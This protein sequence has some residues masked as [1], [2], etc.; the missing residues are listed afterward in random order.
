MGSEYEYFAQVW[1][2]ETM[3]APTALWRTGR[4]VPEYQHPNTQT[5]PEKENRVYRRRR[6]PD[7]VLDEVFG[8]DNEWVAT[9]LIREFTLGPAGD[10]PEMV[11]I[12]QA[13]GEQLIV[14]TRGITGATDMIDE[15][16]PPQTIKEI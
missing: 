8:R 4:G 13:A 2:N 7:R 1:S 10:R 6:S 11:A 14:Q 16:T 5:E 12:D 15:F 9:R 3:D